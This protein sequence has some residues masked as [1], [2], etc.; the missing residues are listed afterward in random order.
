MQTLPVDLKQLIH[1]IKQLQQ[2]AMAPPKAS[3]T[4]S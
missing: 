1:T 4:S 2:G 3:R